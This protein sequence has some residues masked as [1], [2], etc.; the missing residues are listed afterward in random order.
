M[1]LP[2]S[3]KTLKFQIAV[4]MLVLVALL[5]FSTLYTLSVVR[6]QRDDDA[7]LR[8]S[9]E[10]QL[11]L[12]S[13]S[14]Q[15]MSYKENA[16]RDY[17]TYYRDVRLYYR[18]LNYS[19]TRAGQLIEG[20][21]S[22]RLA[23]QLTG[24]NHDYMPE[25]DAATAA[26]IGQLAEGWRKFSAGLQERLGADENEPRLEWGA[27]YIEANVG[28]LQDRALALNHLLEAR[29]QRQ[30]TQA[31]RLTRLVLVFS[32]AIAAG[33]LIWFYL[34]V[35]GPL[36]AT[37]QGFRQVANGDFSHRVPVIGDN[38]IGWLSQAFNRLTE[39]LDTLFRL[40]TRLQQGSDLDQ[41]LDFVSETL[42]S[43]VPI[44]Y[45]GLLVKVDE[46]SLQVERVYVEGRPEVRTAPVQE[47]RFTLAGTLL[48]ECLNLNEPLHI[49]DVR[50]L[51]LLN[52][53][54][55]FLRT[56]DHLGRREAM[57]LPIS[58]H[59]P[60]PGVLVFASR[61][62]HAYGP[63]Q[64]QLLGNI[65]LL[66]SVG[67]GRSLRIAEHA[68]LVAI[69]Q[70]ASGIAHEIRSPLATLSLAFDHL[71][72]T[73]QSESSRKRI[74]LGHAE[75]RRIERLLDDML[76]YAKPLQLRLEPIALAELLPTLLGSLPNHRRTRLR[77]KIEST[78]AKI[79]ADRDR[80]LQ[81]LANLLSNAFDAA[82]DDGEVTL[83]ATPEDG[84]RSVRIGVANPAVSG[85]I[86]DA[87]RVFEPF[88]TTKP[89]GTGL[90]LAIV[91]RLVEAHGGSIEVE[92]RSAS[93]VFEVK[94]PLG[95]ET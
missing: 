75:V 52:P 91:R 95:G 32:L 53:E 15:A 71:R 69:G 94:L 34:R 63:E 25:F 81:V 90:G 29:V 30:V 8:L 23:M 12:Q 2:R 84:S 20:F 49:A 18:D 48:E 39:R 22:S 77:I 74:D 60:V 68:R 93:T 73:E 64:R 89:E 41:T 85:G 51:S 88:Y 31:D 86:P 46:H 28:D 44:D 14:M 78:D 47:R 56:L 42:P 10:L 43:L 38:E 16:P 79:P 33:V 1:T 80:L 21:S 92:S 58:S 72:G 3:L 13:L 27:E 65:G 7:V 70:F 19:R 82:G 83:Y 50:E 35:L 66:I 61:Q 59:S 36:G 17:E 76:L 4:A 9:G 67:F 57:F 55:R 5:A 26:E 24:L 54:Y 37:V 45:V 62:A 11:L 40:S 6:Q 87:D